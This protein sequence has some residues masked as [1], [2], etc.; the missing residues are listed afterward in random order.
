MAAL[1]TFVT[2]G[3]FVEEE[4]GKAGI[5]NALGYSNSRIIHKF[6]IYGLITSITGTTAGVITGHTLLPI[7]IHNTYKSGICSFLLLNCT[8]Y[9]GLTLVAFLLG[10]LSAVL[11]AFV[12]AKKELWENLPNSSFQNHLVQE[13]R[14]S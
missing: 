8:S 5:F 9:L 7:L 4:R 11:P 13:L 10:L 14:L 3:R 12:V 6:V 1:V 2:M